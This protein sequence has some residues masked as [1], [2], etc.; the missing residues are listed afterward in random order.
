MTVPDYEDYWYKVSAYNAVGE[1]AEAGP[2][3]GYRRLD[4]PS[5]PTSVEATDGTFGDRIQVTWQSL[6]PGPPT[7]GFNIYRSD[8]ES[9]SYAV[10]DSSPSSPF[11][12]TTVPD[13]GTYWYKVSA[14]NAAGESS[15]AGPDSGCRDSGQQPP[16]P[17]ENVEATK[18]AP[19]DRVRIAWVPPLDGGTPDTYHIY[20]S[21]LRD[22]G[23]NEVGSVPASE[24]QY[25]DVPPDFKLY[26]FQ[27]TAKNAQGESDP[28][29]PDFGYM[30]SGG[31]PPPPIRPDPPSNVQASDGTYTDRIEITWDAP[32]DTFGLDGYMVWR[33]TEE[34]G[35][36]S[37]IGFTPGDT[38]YDDY[39]GDYRLYWYKVCSYGGGGASDKAGP[40]SGSRAS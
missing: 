21:L 22:E 39:V 30:R 12:D 2:D 14:Y 40:D 34:S 31:P 18:G 24:T 5:T 13:F 32:G 25:D 28:G 33:A 37:Y 8:S 20:R 35:Y 7:D 38:T 19:T 10:I 3:S 9:G 15:L 1:S 36:Y 29:G 4:P 16:N 26:W 11:D 27:V 17:P 23:Y 6:G